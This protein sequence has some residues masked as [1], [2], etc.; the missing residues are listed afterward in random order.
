[1]RREN[2]PPH[3]KSLHRQRGHG[4]N[5]PPG[6]G[7]TTPARWQQHGAQTV[8][9]RQITTVRCSALR[10]PSPPGGRSAPFPA[11][12]GDT[13][14]APLQRRVGP[15]AAHAPPRPAWSDS[16]VGLLLV[17]F[18]SLLSPSLSFLFCFLKRTPSLSFGLLRCGT[19]QA[20]LVGRFVETGLASNNAWTGCMS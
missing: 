5:E 14:R 6:M 3:L 11:F 13:A 20:S 8:G 7:N 17:H 12:P 2:L 4:P 1:M 10:R 16:R 15:S 18:F 19:E 9:S